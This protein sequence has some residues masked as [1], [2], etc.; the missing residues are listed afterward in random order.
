MTRYLA[1]RV[2]AGLVTLVIFATILF[3]M[4]DLLMPGDFVTRFTL[5][6][7]AAQLAELRNF[8]GL[9]RPLL[10]RYIDYMAGLATGDL[11]LSFWGVSVSSLLWALLPWTLLVFVVAMG[12]AFPV[13]F[14]LGKRAAWRSGTTGSAGL[15]VGSVALNTTFPPLLVFIL[16][17][18]VAR[19]TSG[20]GITSLHRLFLSGEL[21]SATVWRMLGTMAVVAAA[22]VAAG[23]VLSRIGKRLPMPVWATS[24]V[25]G[26]VLV[27]AALGVA[28][29]A[30]DVLLYLSLPI[31]AVT[32]LAVGEV[33][34]VTK[35]TTGAAAR[36]DFVQTARA[37]GV[38]EA[39]IRDH[40][41]ARYAVLPT[42]S[43]LAVSVPF[44]LAGLMIVEVSFGWPEAGTLG[45][46][47]P[48]LSSMLF[49]SLE[50]RDVPVVVGGLFA[51]GVIM[52]VL[53]LFL[54]VAH[55]VLDPRIRYRGT[56]A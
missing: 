55:A 50:Q 29:D 48:G 2:L 10:E 31:I 21:T 35:A 27:W 40:H 3:L 5:Q 7:D 33:V 47:V 1:G 23:L 54:D 36:E 44:V 24:L 53:R 9:D 43:K 12:I 18:G 28:G 39:D 52:L 46:T 16:V 11:G 41:A 37:K 8:L 15:T 20:T 22:V 34:L 38:A 17:I 19:L 6:M 32:L 4:T 30:F 42:L 14:W 56:E 26:P 49:N 25:V 51:I 45:L 13:G